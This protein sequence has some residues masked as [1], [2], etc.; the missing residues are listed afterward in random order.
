MKHLLQERQ[1]NRR[2]LEDQANRH[3]R[4]EPTVGK[5]AA[6]ESGAPLGARV[7]GVDDLG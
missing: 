1:V 3:R 7:E 5:Q 2:D 4:P 6:G